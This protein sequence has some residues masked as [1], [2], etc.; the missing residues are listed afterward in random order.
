[1]VNNI[2]L[3][4]VKN[5]N[6]MLR[7]YRDQSAQIKAEINVN[8]T[9]LNRLCAEISQELG[10][11]V[12]PDNLEMVYEQRVAKVNSTLANGMDILSRIQNGV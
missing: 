3:E 7:K 11:E 6:A 8:K 1:M 4:Q 10:M 2:D 5:Y 9:E 12:T